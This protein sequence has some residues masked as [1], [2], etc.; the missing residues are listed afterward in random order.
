MA[1]VS[2]NPATVL[3]SI[4]KKTMTTTT[5]ALECQS[6]PNHITKIGAVPMIG[7]AARKFP[8]GSKPRLRKSKRSTR[9]A[10]AI[11]AV[12][13]IKYPLRAPLTKV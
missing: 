11:A 2:L 3:M 5:A 1:V 12:Q 4:G 7:S 10:K 9:I 6:N 8:T 13:P